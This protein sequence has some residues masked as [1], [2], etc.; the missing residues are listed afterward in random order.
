MTDVAPKY[1]VTIHNENGSFWAEVKGLP[2]CFAAGDTPEDLGEAVAE[3]IGMYLSSEPTY[4]AAEVKVLTEA[5][6]RLGRKEAG[7][8]IAVQ[9]AAELDEFGPRAGDY[10]AG[11][12]RARRIAVDIAWFT[13][14]AASDASSGVPEGMEAG[15]EPQAASNRLPGGDA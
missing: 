13:S 10:A 4:T 12:N 5:A 14:G 2:G 9:I 8:E 11:M 7:E 15:S 6:L 3:A 1:T